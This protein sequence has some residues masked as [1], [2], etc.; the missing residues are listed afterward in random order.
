[1]K[2]NSQLR[3]LRGTLLKVRRCARVVVAAADA[4]TQRDGETQRAIVARTTARTAICPA[5]EESHEKLAED[6][7]R[8]Q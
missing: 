6:S 3:A 5:T 4:P 7:R 8:D 2:L 1:M